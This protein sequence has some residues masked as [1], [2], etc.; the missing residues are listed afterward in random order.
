MPLFPADETITCPSI[1]VLFIA[2]VM[3]KV[4][5]DIDK[6]IIELGSPLS[7]IHSKASITSDV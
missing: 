4:G 2:N 6:F 3:D 1:I 7:I 5:A